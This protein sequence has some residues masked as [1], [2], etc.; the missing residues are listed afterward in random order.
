MGGRC[1]VVQ[2]SLEGHG[3]LSASHVRRIHHFVSQ[4]RGNSKLSTDYSALRSSGGPRRAHPWTYLVGS[5][6]TAVSD[7]TP[8]QENVDHPSRWKLVAGLRSQFWHRWSREYLNS[9]QQRHKWTRPRSNLGVG[10][11]VIVLD[12]TL[13]RPNGKWPFGRVTQVHPGPDG[14]V[15]AATVR[16]STED[17]KRPIVKLSSL[18]LSEPNEAGQTPAGDI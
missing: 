13:L 5:V 14:L 15:R 16:P 7:L 2:D 3:G 8:E 4:H 1:K 17:Y 9:L 10:D 12:A 11:L 18:P 6:L